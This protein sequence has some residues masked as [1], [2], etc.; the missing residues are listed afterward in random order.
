MTSNTTNLRQLLQ[1]KQ[2]PFKLNIYLLER[3]YLTNK[4]NS[5]SFTSYYANASKFLTIRDKK[6]RKMVS[7]FSMTIKTLANKLVLAKKL[8]PNYQKQI[9]RRKYNWNCKENKQQLSSDFASQ[10]AHSDKNSQV[11]NVKKGISYISTKKPSTAFSKVKTPYLGFH[12]MMKVIQACKL[13][14]S[15]HEHHD[16][17]DVEELGS[18]LHENVLK[19]SKH[20]TNDNNIFELWASF[21]HWKYDSQEERIHV[22]KMIGDSILDDIVASE[23]VHQTIHKH[24]FES[25]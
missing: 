8:R 24:E 13:R 6:R 4:P 3:H 23:F 16:I 15:N 18:S 19:W 14:N 9:D 11:F 7:R 2:E 25:L 1:H 12:R 20:S 22:A 10:E 5:K 21:D 17:M